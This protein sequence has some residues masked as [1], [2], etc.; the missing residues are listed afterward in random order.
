MDSKKLQKVATKF[1]CEFCDYNTSRKS[2]YEKHLSTDKHKMVV[3]DSEKLQKVANI[4]QCSC[5]KIYKYDSGYYRHKKQCNHSKKPNETGEILNYLMKE[6]TDF[7]Q[8][9][10]EQNKQMVELVKN[11]GNYNIT[12]NSN[13]RTFNLN[14][15]LNETCKNAMNITEF[16][17]SLHLQLSDLEKVGEIGY[18]E[19]ISNIIIKNLNAMDVTERPIHCTDKKRETMYIKDEDKWEKENERK[20][21]MHRMV[22]K[23][24]N[25]N[26]N[27]ITT[28]QE[29]YP[30][31]KKISSK[32]SDQY[33]KIIIESMGGKGENEHEKEEKIIKKIA[34]EVFV[35]KI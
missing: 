34:K 25:K 24:A 1:H 3:N 26:I 9:L 28:F 11:V 17:D 18:I 29:L 6:N 7:K 12:N 16:I 32:Y 5:G 14:I 20:E 8:L 13:N 23:I 15:F 19:G 35:D 4:L 10:I 30:E 27:L 31:Y 2:S 22:K 21:K 33:N